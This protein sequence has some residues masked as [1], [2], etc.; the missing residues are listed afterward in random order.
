MAN[1]IT[2]N[3]AAP[4]QMNI[5]VRRPAGL[6]L[7][8][9]SSPMAPPSTAASS[10]RTMVLDSKSG[11]LMCAR[12]SCSIRSHLRFWRIVTEDS[13][14]SA[15]LAS[16]ALI[17]DGGR[18]ARDVDVGHSAQPCW[19]LRHGIRHLI[20]FHRDHIVRTRRTRQRR[21]PQ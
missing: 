4:K 12:K 11:E 2:V 3:I 14:D 13:E 6:R 5:L 20:A 1:E 21:I 18:L 19:I 17:K 7:S 10:S 16:L 15:L 9:R 8:S